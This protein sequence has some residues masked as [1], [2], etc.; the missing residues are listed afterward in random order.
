M[1]IQQKPV[2]PIS[3]HHH[4]PVTKQRTLSCQKNQK[5]QKLPTQQN[6]C[7]EMTP[8]HNISKRNISDKQEPVKIFT[9]LKLARNF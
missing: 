4:S 9:D 1:I 2:T 7:D 3:K 6:G 5:N 8:I